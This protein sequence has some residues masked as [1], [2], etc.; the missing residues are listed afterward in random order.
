M[1]AER[2]LLH[3]QSLAFE[4]EG[5]RYRIESRFDFESLKALI[6]KPDKRATPL[7]AQHTQ[8]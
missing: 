6:V 2:M 8:A 4:D 5:V 7:F 1:G 3:A